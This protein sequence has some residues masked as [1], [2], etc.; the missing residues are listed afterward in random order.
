MHNIE[1]HREQKRNPG[2]GGMLNSV[3]TG[4]F[5]QSVFKYVSSRPCLLH[6]G[7]RP[8][9]RCLAI[10]LLFLAGGGVGVVVVVVVC[11]Q[12]KGGGHGAAHR[13]FDPLESATYFA[14]YRKHASFSPAFGGRL[15]T[16]VSFWV[17][18][19]RPCRIG[20][21]GGSDGSSKLL[22]MDSSVASDDER[23]D[24][25]MC[26]GWSWRLTRV[27][28]SHAV[29]PS[30]DGVCCAGSRSHPCCMLIRPPAAPL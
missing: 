29:V 18:V 12:G 13:T 8:F 6:F 14:L 16:G 4:S 10:P 21:R 19:L 26:V 17:V 28:C 11:V 22:A 30:P 23:F 25:P 5:M 27:P 24:S 3:M 2:D 9:K 20:K 7:S 1:A 15:L